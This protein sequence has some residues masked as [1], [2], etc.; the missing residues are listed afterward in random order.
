MPS[1]WQLLQMHTTRFV[2]VLAAIILVMH[3]MLI[4]TIH[5]T[6]RVPSRSIT[7]LEWVGAQNAIAADAAATT[8][9]RLAARFERV[10]HDLTFRLVEGTASATNKLL[11]PALVARDKI[12]GLVTAWCP[13]WWRSASYIPEFRTH[14]PQL[15][16]ARWAPRAIRSDA[17]QHDMCN[18]ETHESLQQ[19]NAFIAAEEKYVPLPQ[20]DGTDVTSADPQS[21]ALQK[22]TL[23]GYDPAHSQW[24][25]ST[26]HADLANS[27]TTAEITILQCQ[28]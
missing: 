13:W 8:D 7:F 20:M 3:A 10:E 5:D 4:S 24:L 17:A 2:L 25:S 16:P 22:P 19:A 28:S 9:L 15:Q 12:L 27:V 11:V 18:T 26:L 14:V 21:D 23:G 6:Y 1:H